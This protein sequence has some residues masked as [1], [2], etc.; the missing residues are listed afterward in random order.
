MNKNNFCKAF[1]NER[2]RDD[3]LAN[4]WFRNIAKQFNKGLSEPFIVQ[5]IHTLC[6]MLDKN[7]KE[8]SRYKAKYGELN[9]SL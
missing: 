6:K 8:L 3:L 1:D 9:N 4:I 5:T 2:Y 7:T